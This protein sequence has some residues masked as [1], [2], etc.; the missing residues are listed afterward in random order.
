MSVKE[1]ITLITNDDNSLSKGLFYDNVRDYQGK[2]KVNQ[3]IIKTLRDDNLQTLLPL[4]NNGITII[5]KKLTKLA[6]S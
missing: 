2:N 1:Y 3:E 6:L 5:A 4:L